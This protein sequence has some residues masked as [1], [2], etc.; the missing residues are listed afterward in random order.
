MIEFILFRHAKT[1]PAKHG[2]VDHDR[3]LM[4]RGVEDAKLVARHLYS[5]GARPDLIIHS[6]AQRCY[7]TLEAI[8]STFNNP[9]TTSS[10]ELYLAE[11]HTILNHANLA[12][13]ASDC[14]SVLLIGH[15]PGIQL[16][17]MQL[18][19]GQ[20]ENDIRIRSGYP[21]SAAGLF[22]RASSD[23]DWSLKTFVTPKDLKATDP[24]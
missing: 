23:Q 12:A 13:S 21:T 22:R 1:H 20:N 11:P 3:R 17:A 4:P 10:P 7:E 16:L 15:N 8:Q 24:A 9:P 18:A 19:D 5:L 14:Q 2:E 6:D